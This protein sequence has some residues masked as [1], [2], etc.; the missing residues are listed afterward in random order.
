[1]E[2][3]R[4]KKAK[5]IIYAQ[6]GFLLNI[7]LKKTLEGFPTELI[8]SIRKKLN[9]S[10]SNLTEKYNCN[11]HYFGYCKNKDVDCLYIYLQK[12]QLRI[13]L[14]LSQQYINEIQ[15]N[16][17]EVVKVNNNFQD[18]KGWITGWHIPQ[19]TKDITIIMK[20]LT[21]VFE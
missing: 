15:S 18:E 4:G 6:S 11:A 21:K 5:Y 8:G 17:F 19:S 13:D 14:R 3:K 10:I 2:G 12:K 1:M 16:G 7:D 9:E 20:Y